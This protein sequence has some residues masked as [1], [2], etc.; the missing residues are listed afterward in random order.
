M[1][2]RLFLCLLLNFMLFGI[3]SATVTI[4]LGIGKLTDGVAVTLPENTLWALISEDSS[5]NLPGGLGVDSSLFSSSNATTLISHFGGASITPG[6]NIGGGVVLATGSTTTAASLFTE[7][8]IDAAVN[9]DISASGLS[10]GDKLGVYWFPGRTVASNTLPAS[11]FDIGG[12]HRTVPNVSSGGIIGLVVPSDNTVDSAAYIDNV[13]TEGASGIAAT[14]FQAIT[15]VPEPSTIFILAT[16][17][18]LSI[19]RRRR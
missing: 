13:T 10:V 12:F 18:L 4:N 19:S 3:A 16:S 11:S 2:I 17:F 6:A 14:E 5:G 9:F 1:K 8:F 7:G 15:V